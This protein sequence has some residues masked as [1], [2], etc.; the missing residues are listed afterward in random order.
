ME[1]IVIYGAG[2]MARE[3]AEL[4]EAINEER[5]TWNILG[6]LDD[7]R[8]DCGE[9]VDGYRILG[10][11]GCLKEGIVPENLVL[12]VG[13]PSARKIL[14]ERVK[15]LRFGF[16]AL[17][18]PDARISKRACIGEGSIVSAGCRISTGAVIGRQVFLNFNSVVGH[19]ASIGDFSSCLVNSVIAGGASLGAGCLLGSNSV[20]M[21][22]RRLGASVKVGMGA[23]ADQDI[24]DGYVVMSRPSRG[25]YFGE[26]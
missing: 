2:G 16:P 8:E 10:G 7:F 3:V 20:V 24:P 13:D 1:D 12:A 5:P 26:K 25:M 23:V 11:Y 15:N 21:E 9:T 22:R 17:V 4:I 18:H 6:F 19:D 14:W